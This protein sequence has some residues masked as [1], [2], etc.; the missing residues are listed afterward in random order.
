[1]L[2]TGSPAPSLPP[3][4]PIQVWQGQRS[5][6]MGPLGKR[7]SKEGRSILGKLCGGNGEKEGP[8]V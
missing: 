4:T 8:G 1:M 2:E 3:S 7:K 6:N 5:P